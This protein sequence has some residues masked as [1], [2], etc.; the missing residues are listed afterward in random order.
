MAAYGTYVSD[1]L[2]IDS[3]EIFE[4][5]RNQGIGGKIVLALI[6]AHSYC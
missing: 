1:L 4:P 2:L 6:E 5:Y 3:I